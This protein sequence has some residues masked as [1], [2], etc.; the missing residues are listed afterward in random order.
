MS[1]RGQLRRVVVAATGRDRK[2]GLLVAGP[3]RATC[4]LGRT[5]I[6]HNKHEG[7]G[8]TPAG[9][10]RTV[11]VFYR[12]DRQPHPVTRLQ[13]TPIRPNLG[14]CDDPDSR[15]YNRFV[16]LPHPDRHERLWRDDHLYDV[17]VVLDYNLT[18]P[19][20]GAGSAIFLHIAAPDF[21]PTSGC[22]ALRADAMRAL[23]MLVGPRTLIDVR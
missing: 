4:A 15:H 6:R 16:R 1:A 17:I 13:A 21:A 7:D 12:A 10:W 5:G 11:A 9:R 8:T 3:L 19:K 22:I 14:W 23:L 2:R 20:P 18:S